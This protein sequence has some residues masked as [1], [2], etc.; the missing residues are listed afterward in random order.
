M[1]EH[2]TIVEARGLFLAAAV[3]APLAALSSLRYVDF[4]ALSA[5]GCVPLSVL[6]KYAAV[7]FR[8]CWYCHQSGGTDEVELPDVLLPPDQFFGYI[9]TSGP[10][11]IR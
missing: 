7:S 9:Y 10:I 11:C 8:V 4:W 3:V 5:T 1:C 2:P 6:V